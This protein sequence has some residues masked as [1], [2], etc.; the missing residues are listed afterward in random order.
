MGVRNPAG[1]SLTVAWAETGDKI[2]P[3][4]PVTQ[5]FPS[6]YSLI[7]SNP[8]SLNVPRLVCNEAWY[9]STVV[10]VDVNTCGGSLPWVN[11]ISYQEGA[12]VTAGDPSS[13]LYKA[14]ISNF[15]VDPTT[16]PVTWQQYVLG[17]TAENFFVDITG[18]NNYS[19]LPFF[20][21]LAPSSYT[22]GLTIDFIPSTTNTG[23]S[24][25]NID[26]LG[27]IPVVDIRLNPLISGEMQSTGVVR[28][29]YIS[30]LG[31]FLLQRSASQPIVQ[32]RI[33]NTGTILGIPVG[34]I[35]A[36]ITAPFGIEL[37]GTPSPSQVAYI[38]V[39]F[40]NVLDT[41]NYDVTYSMIE[42]TAATVTVCVAADNS[43]VP[44]PNYFIPTAANPDPGVN[45]FSPTASTFYM[46]P[47]VTV[48]GT[49]EFEP[50]FP[51]PPSNEKTT[52]MPIGGISVSVY[53]NESAPLISMFLSEIRLREKLGKT[54]PKSFN[55]SQNLIKEIQEK[56]KVHVDKLY[57]LKDDDQAKKQYLAKRYR[58][59]ID[60]FK[61]LSKKV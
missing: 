23:A 31:A 22:E 61:Q 4:F 15:N 25:I 27:A 35:Q 16:N 52:L 13:Q 44:D 59:R 24:T 10:D 42:R 54:V 48:Y 18:G 34:I 47:I 5:G 58:G 9:L 28:A 36:N 14:S 57:E 41:A 3:P 50:P 11:D 53:D 37:D 32:A 39:T 26:G 29:T 7:P 12:I 51:N 1:S 2:T 60:I 8:A 49:T 20:S 21:G 33:D 56:H 46:I 17:A 38:Q 55:D 45:V 6:D 19:L 40:S 30:S 43:V